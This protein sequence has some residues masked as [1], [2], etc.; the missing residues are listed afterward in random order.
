[1]S[2]PLFSIITVTLNAGDALGVTVDSIK[3]QTYRDFEHIVKDAGSRDGS[4]Q[5]YVKAEDAYTPVVIRQP[6]RG[7]Y[8]AMNQ[9]LQHATGTYVLFLNA[10]DTL[11]HP[12]VLAEVARAA[13]AAP[14]AG[15]VYGDYVADRLNMVVR[16]PRALSDFH[17]FRGPLC[18]QCC[19]ARRDLLS[20]S[21]AF[22]TS[23][24]VLADYDALLR[25]V[26]DARCTYRHC[27]TIVASYMGE[28]FSERPDVAP[29]LRREVELI[30]GRH[31]TSR[32]RLL[33][34]LLWSATLPRLRI[35][36]MSSNKP[37]AFQRS[38]LRVVN[39]WKSR[40]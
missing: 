33:Y 30:R 40:A 11:H 27:G 31:F 16:N 1:M 8:D 23:L 20:A 26:L 4:V 15:L 36:L 34:R 29:Q 38:Y 17:L 18:H 6:D 19:F 24:K 14:E 35:R 12:E 39:A 22:D 2:H 32:Q 25:L 7:I 5:R 21:G 28:G 10:G 9:A 37:G 13:E 3:K